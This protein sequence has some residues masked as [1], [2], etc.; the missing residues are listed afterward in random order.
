MEQSSKKN[1]FYTVFEGD[2]EQLSEVVTDFCIGEYGDRCE[3]YEVSIQRT[4]PDDHVWKVHEFP[5]FDSRAVR[6]VKHHLNA[7][8]D[9]VKL[10]FGSNKRPNMEVMICKARNSNV[11]ARYISQENRED[12]N[13]EALV[14]LSIN[15]SDLEDEAQRLIRDVEKD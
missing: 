8:R 5:S 7:R 3:F 6:A 10:E 4:H 14:V 15:H 2:L 13:E 12:L 1:A 9:I 11:L